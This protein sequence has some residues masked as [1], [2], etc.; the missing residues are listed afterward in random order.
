MV[1]LPADSHS[2][3]ISNRLIATRLEVKPTTSRS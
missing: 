1:Y 2:R 3:P